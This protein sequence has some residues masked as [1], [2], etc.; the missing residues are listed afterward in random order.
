MTCNAKNEFL[1]MLEN[2]E[3]ENCKLVAAEIDYEGKGMQKFSC[4]LYA[5]HTPAE[6]E[7]F[8]QKL[9]FNYDNLYGAQFLFGNAWFSDESWAD[10]A[11]YDGSEWWRCY[12]RPPLPIRNKI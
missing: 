4:I 7:L 1:A 12:K 11:E 2:Y 8:L 6:R 5:D 9:D 3:T 10:R